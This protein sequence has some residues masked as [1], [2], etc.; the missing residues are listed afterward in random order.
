MDPLERVRIGATSMEVTRLGF[1][2]ATLGDANEIISEHQAELTVE[3]AFAAG[4]AYFDTAPWYGNGKSEHRLGR[5]LRSKPRGAFALSTKVGRVYT[6]PADPATFHQDRWAGGLPFDLDFDY[7]RDGV[8]RAYEQSM[9]RLGMTEIDALLVHDLDPRHQRSEEG[10]RRGLGQLDAGGGY[11]ALADMRAR[12]EI[13]AIG[14]GVNLTGMIPRF[15][16]RFDLDFF[17]VA[18]PHTLA[19]QEMLGAQRQL[20]VE[21]LLIGE[22]VRHRD[23]EEV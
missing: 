22:R 18:M 9:M 23:Q 20:R 7:T 11:Q 1:G 2:G 12:G 14:A 8:L 21:H 19:D 16:E 3:A 5:V 4:V 13:R 15:L 17:L 10:V 6:R